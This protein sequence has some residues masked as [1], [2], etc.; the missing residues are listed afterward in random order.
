ME[1]YKEALVGLSFKTREV[2]SK[3]ACLAT[4]GLER[5]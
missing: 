2:S 1:L 5:S 3:L 4:G